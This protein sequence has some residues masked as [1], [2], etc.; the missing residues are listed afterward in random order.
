[1]FIQHYNIHL[2]NGEVL[3]VGEDYE[4]TGDH[5][6]VARFGKAPDDAIFQIGD[7]MSGFAYVPKKSIVFISTGDVINLG[8]D[9]DEMIGRCGKTPYSK[10]SKHPNI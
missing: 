9:E 4:L 10:P 6:L 3:H 8:G 5:A 2:I 1:M 7:E